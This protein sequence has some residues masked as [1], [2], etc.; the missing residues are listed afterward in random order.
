M[1]DNKDQRDGRDRSRVDG[2][3]QYELR[4]IAEKM[5][6]STEEVQ[7]AI[8]SVGNNRDKVEEYLRNKGRA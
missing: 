5:N 8:E 2:N 3:E 1:A 7:R 6:V 4:Y